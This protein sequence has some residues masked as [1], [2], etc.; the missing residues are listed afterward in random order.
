MALPTRPWPRRGHFLPALAIILAVSAAPGQD[1]P[2]AARLRELTTQLQDQDA[3]K[4]KL[5]E[6]ELTKLGPA[7]LPALQAEVDGATEPAKAQLRT[8]LQRIERVHRAAIANGKALVVPVA[9]TGKPIAELFAELRAATGV[10]IDGAAIPADAVTTLPR[11]SLALWD[12]VDQVCRKH[13]K[14]TWDVGTDGITVRAEPHAAPRLATASGYGLLFRGFHRITERGEEIVR[15]NALVL[16]PPGSVV[17][18]QHLTYSELIDDKGTN[19]LKS[20]GPWRLTGSSTFGN[21]RRLG[22][23]DYGRVFC[24]APA[25]LVAASA[26]AGATRIKSCK[27]TA[28]V[29]AVVELKKTVEIA[30]KDL[31]KGAKAN[32]GGAALAIESLDTSGERVRIVVEITDQRRVSK[33]K[34]LIYPETPGRIV[35]RDSTGAEALDLTLDPSTGSATFELGGGSSETATYEITARLADKATLTGIELWEPGTVEEVKIPF[36]FKD[37]PITNGR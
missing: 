35:L 12:A 15:S 37:V 2:D 29:R 19:L 13:G 4:Q 25:D 18:V 32:A 17:A 14:L 11:A 26:A 23:P 21:A 27:G 31:A 16:G 5:A 20:S 8:A 34:A 24:E 1:K 7:V 28:I 33:D 10:C 36:A 30:G 22:A 9:A 3:G 6:D